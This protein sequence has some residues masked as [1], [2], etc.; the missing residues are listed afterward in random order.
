MNRKI[1]IYTCHNNCCVFKTAPVENT[2]ISN[3]SNSNIRHKKSGCFIYDPVE[4]RV[5]LVQSRGYLWGPPKGSMEMNESYIECAIREV[6]EETGLELTNNMLGEAKCVNKGKIYYVEHRTCYVDVQSP[7]DA[8]GIGWVKIE[9][10]NRMVNSGIIGLN[11]YARK[12]FYHFLGIDYKRTDW[13]LA[14]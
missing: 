5:L 11:S 7:N 2:Y 14:I 10:L 6:K 4:N 8:N 1:N 12:C 3:P 9:C 13:I